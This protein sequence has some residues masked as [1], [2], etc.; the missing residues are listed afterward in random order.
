MEKL[1]ILFWNLNNNNI[2]NLLLS[3]IKK[4]NIDIA[5]FTEA[6][7][8]DIPQIS[9]LNKNFTLIKWITDG[10]KVFGFAKKDINISKIQGRKRYII[11]ECER[12]KYK[13]NIAGVHLESKLHNQESSRMSTIAD[14]KNDIAVF[15]AENLKTIII[16]DF[17][18]DPFDIQ[19]SSYYFLHAVS[20]K[21]L[22]ERDYIEHDGKIYK[23][24]YNPMLGLISENKKLYGSY[25]YYD[26]ENL[27]WHFYDQCLLR[28][29]VL[30]HFEKVSII[31]KILNKNLI[32]NNK[33]DGSISDH[34]P[35]VLTLKE[36]TNE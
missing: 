15:E 7:G 35:I 33:P 23:K 10:C 25:Y 9:E 6:E 28:K 31:K 14:L 29:D 2:T 4:E 34:L 21:D 32:K 36:S 24:F 19:M 3:L 26:I 11:F 13:F 17:N 1:K 18:I 16:G 27:Y 5:L 12:N 8:I 20:F 30:P 22:I